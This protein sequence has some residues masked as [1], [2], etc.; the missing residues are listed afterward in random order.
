MSRW[1]GRLLRDRKWLS[2]VIYQEEFTRDGA[3]VQRQLSTIVYQVVTRSDFAERGLSRA[4]L[5]LYFILLIG[6]HHWRISAIKSEMW[7]LY[8]Y[9]CSPEI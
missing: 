2:R 1:P 3:Q 9:C 6:R 5:P 4:I 7:A 8:S